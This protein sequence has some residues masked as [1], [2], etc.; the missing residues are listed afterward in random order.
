[1]LISHSSKLEKL[2]EKQKALH[3]EIQRVE[4]LKKHANEKTIRGRKF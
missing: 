3:A 1:M 4:N 2:K